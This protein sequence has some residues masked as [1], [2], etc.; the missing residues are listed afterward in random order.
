MVVEFLLS[1]VGLFCVNVSL[2][3]DIYIYLSVSTARIFLTLL[4]RV[5]K[6]LIQ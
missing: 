1:G 3:N 2:E 4:A 6:I 5:V